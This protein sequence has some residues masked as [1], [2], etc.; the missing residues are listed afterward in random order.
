MR[1]TGQRLSFWA[2]IGSHIATLLQQ[3]QQRTF[4]MKKM[5]SLAHVETQ[6]DCH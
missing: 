2:Q 3:G 1:K 5:K 6:L 4:V